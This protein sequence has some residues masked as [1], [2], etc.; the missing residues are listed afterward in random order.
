MLQAGAV[1]G[2]KGMCEC[3]YAFLL[4]NII[5]LYYYY[6]TVLKCVRRLECIWICANLEPSDWSGNSKT[7][8]CWSVYIGFSAG[9]SRAR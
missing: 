2:L 3:V 5:V 4:Y 8:S 1:K 7:A 9:Y 6:I